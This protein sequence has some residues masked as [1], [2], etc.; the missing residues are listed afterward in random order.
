LGRAIEMGRRGYGGL[1][2]WWFNVA[3]VITAVIRFAGRLQ[4][5]ITLLLINTKSVPNT[6]PQ[7]QRCQLTHG[8]I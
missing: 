3:I 1:M 4:F 6:R 2:G 7:A 8:E 5:L